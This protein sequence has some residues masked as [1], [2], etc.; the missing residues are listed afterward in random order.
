M[1][2]WDERLFAWV[3]TRWRRR[4]RRTSPEEQALL[5]ACEP[6]LGRLAHLASAA[7]QRSV[8]VAIYDG[9][10]LVGGTWVL[11][12]RTIDEGATGADNERLAVLFAIFGGARLTQAAT[13]PP[14]TALD[15]LHRIVVAERALDDAWPG[16]RRDRNQLA[17]A[18]FQRRPAPTQRHGQAMVLEAVARWF[19]LGDSASHASLPTTFADV[20]ASDAI[21]PAMQQAF[22]ALPRTPWQ[23]PAFWG[24]VADARVLSALHLDATSAPLPRGV[25][26]EREGR[27]RGPVRR[28]RHAQPTAA[29]E[30]PLVHSFEKVH[31]AEE[32]KGGSK[33]ADG[34]D[35]L[36]EHS[37]ALDE[38]NL[39]ET[40][41]SSEATQ[42]VYHAGG[43]SNEAEDGDDA[44]A[45]IR[46]DEWDAHRR[47]YLR[48]YCGVTESR[49]TAPMAGGL[50]P[51]A[52]VQR[53]E[54]RAIA[55]VEDAINLAIW[56]HR[57]RTQQ[58]AGEELDLDGVV[59]RMGALS[60]GHE[61]TSRVYVARKRPVRELAVLLLLD[62]SM[63]TDS[64]VD[65]QRVLDME[66]K[67]ALILGLG[68]QHLLGEVMVAGFSSNTHA[69]CRYWQI[70]QAHEPWASAAARLW[71]IEPAGYT[72]MG[73]ALRHAGA[74]LATCAA[75]RR[76]LIV[77]T[78]GKPSDRD[79]YE[80]RHGE[81]DVRQ[82]IREVAR[83]DVRVLG[84]G[85]DPRS[86]EVMHAMFGRQCATGLTS[87]AAV[88]ELIAR[89]VAS[90]SLAI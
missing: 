78:D 1:S 48:G 19:V 57:W 16:W 34:S 63:S 22:A 87:P 74:H 41:V 23:A 72:R 83:H 64:W 52:F 12:P 40:I 17:G 26:S 54:R 21:T 66:R 88:A 35:E 77:L 79:R 50:E 82:A 38:L 42:S 11:L 30:N 25:T 44:V 80:G 60:A 89:H 29:T 9:P 59:E 27:A 31:T 53:T 39:D 51:L 36:A 65:N 5:F 20:L 45:M 68:T 81:A 8:D 7:A 76:L 6:A 46:Y 49:V 67:A 33:R 56:A 84:L 73:P 75:R 62:L 3:A 69:D 28:R 18:L 10:P 37:A 90:R 14:A 55:A 86:A 32:Y 70:K 15:E 85:A 24:S 61:G 43:L 71:A 2:G 13:A 58:R 47:R 4:A